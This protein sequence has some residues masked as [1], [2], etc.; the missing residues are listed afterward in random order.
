MREI[1]WRALIGGGV[2]CT[3]IAGAAY[4]QELE[5][6]VEAAEGA[7]H[8]AA[9]EHAD[10]GH[11]D[12]TASLENPAEFRSD[13]AIYTFV[14]FLL[15][16]AI[17]SRAAWPMI[18][19]ALL[20]REKRIESAIAAAEAKHEEAKRLLAEHEA[21]LAGAALEVRALLEEARRDAEA[22]KGEII[23]DA[24]DAAKQEHD[25]AQRD[26][27]IALDHA[28]KH[29]AET[30]ANLAV[31]LAAKA[32][33]ETINPAKQQELVREALIKLSASAPSRN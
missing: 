10:L 17:L 3:L 33:R 2:A 16:L 32:I 27:E 6:Q 4:S 29:L 9:E 24:R 22:T 1:V 8:A 30:S 21:R 12:A 23:A 15:L 18:S 25:R 13:L 19:E 14:V 28:T 7:E 5:S 11:G 26:I 20:E 31:D